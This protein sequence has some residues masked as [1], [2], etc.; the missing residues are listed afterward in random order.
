M[1]SERSQNKRLHTVGFHLYDILEEDTK[2]I[3]GMPGRGGTGLTK[4]GHK[5]TFWSNGTI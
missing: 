2:Q 3:N 5:H 1:L 4:K